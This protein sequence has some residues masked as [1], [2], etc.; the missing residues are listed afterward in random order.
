MK[1]RSR[2]RTRKK[3]EKR[4]PSDTPLSFLS[5][6]AEQSKL[7]S[8]SD[9]CRYIA[10][11]FRGGNLYARWRRIQTVFLPA[12]W[13]SRALRIAWRVFSIIET[14]A[15]LLLAVALVL[16]ILPFA[17]ILSLAFAA[18]AAYDRRRANRLYASL[19]CGRRVLAF[20]PQGESA[21]LERMAASLAGE[22]TVLMVDQ[23]PSRGKDGKRIPI[24]CAALRRA[25]GVLLVRGHY[26]FHLRRTLLREAEFFAAIF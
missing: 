14:S 4:D 24:T 8:A 1:K 22:Y 21:F 5:E 23:L 3:H 12:L 10:N 6:V 19:F 7:Y 20:F 26:Y 18:R 2:L 16:F 17:L 25:D 11:M 15:F 13:I 9:Y